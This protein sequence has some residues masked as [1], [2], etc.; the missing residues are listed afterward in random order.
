MIIRK[1]PKEIEIMRFGGQALGNVLQELANK[2][3]PGMSTLDLDLIAQKLIK[4]HGAIAAFIDYTPTKGKDFSDP[5]RH[6]TCISI[7]DELIH[8]IP[9]KDRRFKNGDVVKID[10]GLRKGGFYSDAA[11]TVTVGEVSEQALKLISVTKEALSLGIQQAKPGNRISDISKAIQ[12][13]VE[14]AGFSS[15]RDFCGHGIGNGLHEDPP[16]PN[17]VDPKRENPRLKEGMVLAIEPMVI[18]SSVN[19]LRKKSDGWTIASSDKS[20]TAHFEHTVAITEYGPWVLTS[21]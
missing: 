18:A 14:A 13:C 10:C 8:G 16:V 11:V 3:K 1:T 6:A 21:P 19:I 7:N 2:I 5:Y 4:D 17:Y 9:S 15:V 12:D 20:L